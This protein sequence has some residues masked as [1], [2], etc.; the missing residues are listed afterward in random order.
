MS[1]DLL[2]V[3]RLCQLLFNQPGGEQLQRIA[4][5]LPLLFLFPGTIVGTLNIADV[6]AIETIGL[7]EDKSWLLALSGP[8]YRLPGYSIDRPHILA[9]YLDALDSKGRR[10]GAD[11]A[12]NRLGVRRIFAVEIV[13]ADID[14]GQLP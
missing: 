10:S 13:L 12:R 2:K 4:P 14:H 7:A 5:G 8:R 6:M 11:T 9:I 1:R 3:G